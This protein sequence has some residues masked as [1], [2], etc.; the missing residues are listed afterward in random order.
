MLKSMVLTINGGALF[1]L[2]V[3]LARTHPKQ[4]ASF[5]FT[6]LTNYTGWSSDG[7]VFFLGLLPG[8]TAVNA[9]DG[10]AHLTDGV[11]DPRRDVPRVM[12]GSAVLSALTGLPMILVY[13]FCIINPAD[14]LTSIGGQPI[15]Q[16]LLDSIR[17]QALTVIGI[18][19]YFGALLVAG[20]CCLT[21]F[22]R[23]VWTVSE[24]KALPLSGL[25][26]K[27]NPYY[28]I[29]LN[30]VTVSELLCMAVDALLLGSSTALNVILGAGIVMCYI[31]YILVIG[32]A[33]YS[34]KTALPTKRILNLGKVSLPLNIIS[35]IWMPFITVWLCFPI[36]VP[37]T[38]DTMNYASAVLG[39]VM[40]CSAVNWFAYSRTRYVVPKDPTMAAEHF[41]T[42]GRE[43]GD[44]RL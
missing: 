18:L 4:S 41:S 2:I 37:V 11:P 7:V 27:I 12:V 44:V 19:V 24:Q 38:S 14:L 5:V 25:W 42:A 16:L 33:L 40:F 32:C 6:D 43:I 36:Y 1:I 22:S 28:R 39:C 15:T 20:V 29:S 23:I 35:I 9:F 30:S 17:S 8:V 10:A 13:M 26:A 21:T 34:R 3:P 31:S